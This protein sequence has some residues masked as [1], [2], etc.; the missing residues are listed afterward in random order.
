MTFSMFNPYFHTVPLFDFSERFPVL[1]G[2]GIFIA[3][4][5]HR[6]VVTAA[7]VVE[8]STENLAFGFAD[9]EN[10]KKFVGIERHE[11]L[12]ICKAK[13][14]TNPGDPQLA[15]YKDHLDLALIRLPSHFRQ[16]LEERYT[17]FDLR[18]NKP[19]P[20]VGIIDVCGWPARKNRFNPVRR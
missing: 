5:E 3:V 6:F 17:P 14:Q 11:K 12:P 8:G 18:K 9:Y 15:T 20:A 1:K 16:W 19:R 4:D 10:G 2:S 7:H 13:A